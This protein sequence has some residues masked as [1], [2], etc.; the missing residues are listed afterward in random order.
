MKKLVLLGG[1]GHCES[2]IEV[3]E[4]LPEEYSIV[5]ILD[6]SY[7]EDKAQNVLGYPLLGTD[8]LVE[9]YRE[10]GCSFV[11]TTGQIKS[12]AIRQKLFN[13]VVQLNG[14]LPTIVARTAYVSK[15]S[16]LGVGTVVMHN[17]F[18]NS[19]VKVGKCGI[20]NTKATI[21]HG[22]RV[23]D[24]CHISTGSIPNGQVSIGNNCF[25]GSNTVVAN[26]I[27][28]CDDVIIAAGS[29]VLKDIDRSGIYIGNPLQKIK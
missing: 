12:S 19:N 15:H 9:K 29:Q 11:I 27:T 8:Y 18:V 21:E 14:D 28:I 17:A 23:G 10:E 2:V 6:V 5:G 4:S 16:C 24:F 13:H 3:I 20:I 26:N 1:G 22:C 7:R 25:I